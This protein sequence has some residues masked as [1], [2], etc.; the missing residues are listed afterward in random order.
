MTDY[1]LIHGAWH[2]SWCWARVRRLLAAGAHRVFT[3]TLTGVGERSHLLS[4]DVGLDTHIEDVANLMIWENL[5]DIVLVGHSY[6]G[7]VVRHVADRMPDRVSSL[8]YLD[9]FVPENG[10]ALFD[11]LPDGGEGLRELAVAHGDGWK[12]PPIP[13]SAFAV[14]AADADWVDRQCIRF[15]VVKRRRRSAA[16]ATASQASGTF[17]RGAMTVL[18]AS[19]TPRQE[20]AAGGGRSLHAG[21]M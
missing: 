12:I 1:V 4:R 8:I 3:P 14:N 13:A 7:V 9:A 2:G 6:G 21:M 11:Y 19:F 15:P 16:P 10:K 18:L 5:R 20:S 17:W